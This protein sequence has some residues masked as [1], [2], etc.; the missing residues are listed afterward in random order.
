MLSIRSLCFTLGMREQRFFHNPQAALAQLL[1]PNPT[2]IPIEWIEATAT[3][4]KIQVRHIEVG[5]DGADIRSKPACLQGH[6]E[7]FALD[8]EPQK[9]FAFSST[10]GRRAS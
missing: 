1:H 6:R 3:T 7:Q 4:V 5:V 10:M 9:I 8:A 2:E